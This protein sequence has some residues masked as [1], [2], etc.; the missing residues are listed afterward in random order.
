[1]IKNKILILLCLLP[2]LYACDNNKTVEYWDNHKAER[3]DYLKKC[4]NGDVD[5]SSQTCENAR[6]SKNHDHIIFR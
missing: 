3:K 5:R 2:F 6:I 4:A 1:M